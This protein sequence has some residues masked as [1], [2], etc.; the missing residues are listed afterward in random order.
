MSKTY[1]NTHYSQLALSLSLGICAALFGLLVTTANPV[2][3]SLGACLI[4]A[5][6]FLIMPELT[7][8]M[9]LI[10]GLTLGILTGSPEYSKFTWGIS[11]LSMLLLILSLINIAWSKQRRPPCFML[12]AL[13]F[14]FYTTGTS[15]IQWHSITEFVAGFKR[16]FQ[17]FGLMMA[18]TMIVFTPQVYV[19]WH[20]FLMIVALL[21]FPFALYQLMVLV[22]LRGD[23]SL[24]SATTDVVA[25]TF[26]GNIKGGSP[27][28]VMVTYLFIALSFLFARWQAGLISNKFFCLMAFIC[29]LP[30][31]MGE[32]KIAVVMLPLVGLILLRENLINAPL[33]YL[34]AILILALLTILLGYLYVTVM[35]RSSLDEVVIGTLQ[36]NIGTQGYS[37]SQFLNRWTSITFWVQQ[38]RWDDPLSFLIGNGLGSS[39]ASKADLSGQLGLKYSHYG[40][41]L[42]A[43][44]TLLWDSGLI[45]FMMFVSIFITAWN[46]ASRLRQS[47][48]DATVKADA[49]AIQAAI[50]L[51][52]LSLIYSDY[53]V[54]LV[55]MELIY[56]LVLG[57]LGYLMN[58]HSLLRQQPSSVFSL[59]HSSVTNQ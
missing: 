32:T 26:G 4:L 17:S 13:L 6:A 51:F 59:K 30:L 25:G 29:L 41:N 2:M 36:Y 44:S 23:L 58:H 20:K 49:I 9:I 47:V 40:I 28:S 46:A 31:G 57:Y 22:P 45:G 50:S 18:L 14:L 1:S 21:Q 37:E 12:L 27:N 55:S 11:L 56:A 54:N 7:V 16:Y 38:Q 19:R 35:M 53:I 43:A 52:F 24:S 48:N 8:W 15:L 42:T 33:R 10:T 34:P 39:Y 3:V 5:P